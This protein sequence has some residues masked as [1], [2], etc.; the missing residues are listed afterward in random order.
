MR[1]TSRPRQAIIIRV[2]AFIAWHQVMKYLFSGQPDLR[3]SCE[4]LLR[5]QPDK[6]SP[7]QLL[8]NMLQQVRGMSAIAA[9]SIRLLGLKHG[10]H[11]SLAVLVGFAM[12]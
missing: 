7:E 1:G 4:Q 11:W 9:A 6:V 3:A 2:V 10:Q 12:P 8:D 5:V